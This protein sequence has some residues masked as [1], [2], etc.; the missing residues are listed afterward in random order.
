[1]SRRGSALCSLLALFGMLTAF[2][3]TCAA[4]P[5]ASAQMQMA[6]CKAG[7]HTCGTTAK[8]ADCC[9]TQG[10]HEQHVTTIAKADPLKQPVWTAWTW[11]VPTLYVDAWPGARVRPVSPDTSPPRGLD[12]PV[13]IRF[14]ALLI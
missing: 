1:M 9:K 2:A 3:A 4:G 5:A 8:P 14:S 6:C 11:A 12:R 13:Y 10:S 7:H